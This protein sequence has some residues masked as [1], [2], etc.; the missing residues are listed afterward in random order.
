MNAEKEKGEDEKGGREGSKKRDRMN[1]HG[2]RE[3]QAG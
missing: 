1:S 3:E 2:E